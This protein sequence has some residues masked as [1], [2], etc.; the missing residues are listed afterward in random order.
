[1][2]TQVHLFKHQELAVNQLKTGSILCGGVGSGKT[3]TSIFYYYTKECGGIIDDEQITP[4]ERPKDLYVIT[5]AA[6]RDTLDWERECSLFMLSRDR[7]ASIN[8][9]QVTVDS[10]NNIAKYVDIKDAFFVFDEQRVVGSGAWVK[11]FLKIT[12]QNNWILLSATPGDTWMDYVP[13][14]IANGFFKNRTDFIRKH[15]VYNTYTKFP[16]VDRYVEEGKLLRLKNDVTVTMSYAKPTESRYE[17][18]IADYDYSKSELI[19]RKRW[20]PFKDAPI[21]D[22]SELC[23]SL[24]KVVNSDPSRLSIVRKLL[25]KHNKIIVFYNFNYELEI[26]R[27]LKCDP[28]LSVAEYN[29]HKHE[30]VPNTPRWAYL[31]QYTS[32]AEGWNCIETNAIIFY[33]LSYS[34]RV[35]TQAAGR[36][37]RLNTPFAVLYYYYILSDSLIDR[38]IEKALKNKKI[39]NE[40]NFDFMELP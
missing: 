6:K 11:S 32:G 12:K 1:M 26:L 3:I 22:V 13:V 34:Y 37:D 2:K 18:I 28:N 24:R 29:G 7:A 36:I 4:M 33:S 21:K 39:F 16:K 23:F 8:G 35:M 5:T 14:F 27:E 17:T 10:W 40:W 30:P 15:V 9:V 38:G 25:I 19:F 31:V 20:N